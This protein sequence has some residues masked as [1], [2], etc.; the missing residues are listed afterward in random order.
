MKKIIVFILC[1]MCLAFCYQAF[2]FESLLVLQTGQGA[3][4]GGG[5]QYFATSGMV[6][7]LAQETQQMT[8]FSG[9]G[10]FPKVLIYGAGSGALNK[11]ESYQ[12]IGSMNTKSVT[13]TTTLSTFVDPNND[14]I[15]QGTLVQ[16]AVGVENVLGGKGTSQTITKTAGGLVFQTQTTGIFSSASIGVGAIQKVTTGSGP[17]DPTAEGDRIS[18]TTEYF[19]DF[20]RVGGFN[21][22]V[23]VPVSVQYSASFNKTV[24]LIPAP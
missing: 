20:Y 12:F 9:S 4:V 18:S 14:K 1:L 3:R 16:S 2:A 21:L 15:T 19:K 22:T 7:G 23:G 24:S 6:E 10:E 13:G 11:E 17:T 5:S 8:S